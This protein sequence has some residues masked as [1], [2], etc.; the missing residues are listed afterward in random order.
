MAEHKTLSE[1]V[2]EGAAAAVA[3]LIDTS[4]LPLVFEQ[5]AR[6]V[7]ANAITAALP[8]VEY[9]ANGGDGAALY[10]DGQ[11]TDCGDSYLADDRIKQIFEI[12]EVDD[13][14]FMLGQSRWGGAAQTLEELAAYRDHRSRKTARIEKLRADAQAKLD[15]ADAIEAGE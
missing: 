13:D 10:V 4:A 9:H 8:S 15:Q 3:E 7:I 1:Y 14:A 12:V 11:L 2:V 6:A 5:D